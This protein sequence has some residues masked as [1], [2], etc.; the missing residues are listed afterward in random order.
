MP[1]GAGRRGCGS[2][3]RC[4][5]GSDP[6][7][8]APQGQVVLL[9]ARDGG[10]RRPR[11]RRVPG[12]SGQSRESR[13]RPFPR[14]RRSGRRGGRRPRRSRVPTEPADG[15][16]GRLH[17]WARARSCARRHSGGPRRRLGSETLWFRGT[18]WRQ[19]L[20]QLLDAGSVQRE[21]GGRPRARRAAGAPSRA[22]LDGRPS[23]PRLPFCRFGFA[24]RGTPLR[25]GDDVVAHGSRAVRSSR[26]R[27]NRSSIVQALQGRTARRTSL[28]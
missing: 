13:S 19:M 20:D 12:R 22:V 24:V 8:S 2:G 14:T 6:R 5:S 23:R 1:A 15:P 27:I 4:G 10:V 11:G 28:S 9:L 25:P 7:R 17:R 18:P 16:E 3:S 26:P 21:R